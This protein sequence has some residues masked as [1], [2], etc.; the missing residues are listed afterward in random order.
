MS[1]VITDID[2]EPSPEEMVEEVEEEMVEV[3]SKIEIVEVIMGKE[4][5]EAIGVVVKVSG[6]V[7]IQVGIRKIMVEE[8]MEAKQF[9]KSATTWWKPWEQETKA[10]K[11]S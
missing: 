3:D 10:V 4:V 2:L 9:W 7:E 1:L 6:T 8:E 11:S 5:L